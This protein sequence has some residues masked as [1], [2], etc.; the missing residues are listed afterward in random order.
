M[1]TFLAPNRVLTDHDGDVMQQMR[2]LC[3]HRT[4]RKCVGEQGQSG[5]GKRT[6]EIGQKV[7]ASS[8]QTTFDLIQHELLLIV[9]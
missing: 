9:Y 2:L 7:G 4:G 1:I 3:C 8:I 5:A 6:E